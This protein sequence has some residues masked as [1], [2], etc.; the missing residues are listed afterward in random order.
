MP[1]RIYLNAGTKFMNQK[2]VKTLLEYNND[3]TVLIFTSISYELKTEIDFQILKKL[4]SFSKSL[5]LRFRDEIK[6]K[7]T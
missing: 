2:M 6:T 3:R 7:K 4:S 1:R 5:T